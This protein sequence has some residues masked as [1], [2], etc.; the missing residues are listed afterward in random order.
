MKNTK[1]LAALA[2]PVTVLLGLAAYQEYLSVTGND[3]ILAIEGYDPRDLLSGNYIRFRIKYNVPR[4]CPIQDGM[5]YM[6]MKPEQRLMVPSVDSNCQEWTEGRCLSG[7]FEDNIN[8]FYVP[9]ENAKAV[10]K[11]VLAGNAKVR[12]SVGQGNHVVKDL[13]INNK[14]W[15]D[16]PSQ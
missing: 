6:C 4:T 7:I 11:E 9:I 12:L 2:I 10:E 3:H 16:L 8:R 14:S 1:L 5:A 13:L 15:K